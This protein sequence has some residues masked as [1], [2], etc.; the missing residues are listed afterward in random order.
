MKTTTAIP[1]GYDYDF[2]T[3]LLLISH[4]GVMDIVTSVQEGFHNA[5]KL[6]GSEVRRAGRVTDFTS[7]VKEAGKV[8]LTETC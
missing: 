7:G 3:T 1:R 5:P 8:S 4:P 2:M 6:Y